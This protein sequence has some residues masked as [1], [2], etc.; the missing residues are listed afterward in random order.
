MSRRIEGYQIDSRLEHCA[1]Q[2]SQTSTSKKARAARA[3]GNLSRVMQWPCSLRDSP[4]GVRGLRST[5]PD[6]TN[7]PPISLLRAG[8]KSTGKLHCSSFSFQRVAQATPHCKR[9]IHAVATFR[10]YQPAPSNA[11]PALLWKA[12]DSVGNARFTTSKSRPDPSAH[13][14]KTA[15][16]APPAATP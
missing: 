7:R 13:S 15:W 14:Q 1:A 4:T 5:S 9:R 11:R 10:E 3:R 8:P 12:D 2:N 6:P 16:P